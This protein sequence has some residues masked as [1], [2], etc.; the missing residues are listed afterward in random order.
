M[1]VTFQELLAYP[2][3]KGSLVAAGQG[4]LARV[5]QSA[6]LI[7]Q[8]DAWNWIRAGELIFISGVSMENPVTELPDLFRKCCQ[9]Q[10]TGMAVAIGP[11]ILDLPQELIQLSNDS[12]VPLIVIPWECHVNDVIYHIYQD[13]F[14]GKDQSHTLDD[15]MQN[16]ITSDDPES[17]A[18]KLQRFGY[19]PA[20]P[21]L[22]ADGLVFPE[23]ISASHTQSPSN[24]AEL[25]ENE[26]DTENHIVLLYR[27]FL[28]RMLCRLRI[29]VC[30]T[31]EK[32]HILALIELSEKKNDRNGITIM[33]EI[34][35]NSIEQFIHLY[36]GTS[37]QIGISNPCSSLSHL[38][39]A[40]TEA[41]HALTVVRVEQKINTCINYKSA[42]AWQLFLSLSGEKLESIIRDTLGPLMSDDLT[43]GE[44]LL[45]TLDAYFEHDRHLKET[46]DTLFIHPNTLK[47]RL[48]KIREILSCDF[49]D[50]HTCFNLQMALQIRRLQKFR[51]ETKN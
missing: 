16:L 28:N 31:S 37:L 3:M 22:V 5:I 14:S 24:P 29:P 8:P 41:R 9:K 7:D 6:H 17:Y 32:N 39:K 30:I 47:Y 13:I 25:H 15:L 50:V 33:T 18:D 21:H 44:E 46:A 38:Q 34:L 11:Y 35:Q 36:P 51:R 26:D 45:R 1:Y 40:L 48:N 20:L 12:N 42:G 49:S 23:N 43:D 4:G 10:I 2:E 27:E 19:H